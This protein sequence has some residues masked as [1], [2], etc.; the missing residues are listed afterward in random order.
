MM[1]RLV[2]LPIVAYRAILSP[3]KPRCCRFE[4]TCSQYA[5][6]AVRRR[7]VWVGLALASWRILRCHPFA[8]PG[9]DPV[10]DKAAGKP[11]DTQVPPPDSV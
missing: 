2:V 6:E 7:G 10:P 9:F 11:A 8:T 1:R 4:P 5:L 3:L